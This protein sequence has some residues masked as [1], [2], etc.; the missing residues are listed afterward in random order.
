M[1]EGLGLIKKP[2]GAVR[3]G[4]RRRGRNGEALFLR[5]MQK[6]QR[7]GSVSMLGL[8][9]CGGNDTISI[10]E[11]DLVYRDVSPATLQFIDDTD[12]GLLAL[13]C[14]HID[15]HRMQRTAV[16]AGN[17]GDLFAVHH[18]RYVCALPFA[19]THGHVDG[20]P[21]DGKLGANQRTDTRISR[22]V[23]PGE[24]CVVRI[25]NAGARMA[26]DH[27]LGRPRLNGE[28]STPEGG[29]LGHP[30]AVRVAL[31]VSKHDVFA[32]Q[33]CGR[34]CPWLHGTKHADPPAR[35]C[36]PVFAPTKR[37]ICRIGT[38]CILHPASKVDIDGSVRRVLDGV[39]HHRSR[40][41]RVFG[42]ERNEGTERL[43]LHRNGIVLLR[44]GHLADWVFPAESNIREALAIEC[45]C[46]GFRAYEEALLH[47]GAVP[48]GVLFPLRNG[49]RVV[50][51]KREGRN[52][53]LVIRL[54]TVIALENIPQPELAVTAEIEL[55]AANAT[56]RHPDIFELL[57]REHLGLT[58][59]GQRGH[60][61][62]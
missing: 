61:L 51:P 16:L 48:P 36:E 20:V 22:D 27:L 5:I 6:R 15:R 44:V 7:G 54:T 55:P 53:L 34:G 35:L 12:A 10:G 50:S 29:A 42:V 4:Q 38:G 24:A 19:A 25:H 62:R 1:R 58:T 14:R 11:D 8:K 59:L 18:H 40:Q 52:T 47:I 43:E 45:S 33:R 9:P 37:G 46:A 28:W 26:G 23:I 3:I 60:P 57:T 2:G 17:T 56:N 41:R 39:A 49:V 32:R 31:E 13:V 21:L 30:I